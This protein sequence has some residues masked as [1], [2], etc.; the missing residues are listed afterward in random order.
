MQKEISKILESFRLNI[1]F[2]HLPGKAQLYF[3][4]RF[5]RYR[6]VHYNI[7]LQP[8]TNLPVFDSYPYFQSERLLLD[9]ITGTIIAPTA[10]G[11]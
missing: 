8:D 7:R 1:L 10:R 3:A 6:L 9:R 4:G 5:E 2:D 11:L